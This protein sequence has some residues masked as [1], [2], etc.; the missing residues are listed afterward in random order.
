MARERPGP[1]GRSVPGGTGMMRTGEQY[2]NEFNDGRIVWVS[3]T[4]TPRGP[5]K[6]DNYGNLRFTV[7][8]RKVE[9]R[10]S[11]LANVTVI[12]PDV[13]Q[14]P[15]LQSKEIHRA[16]GIFSRLSAT[17]ILNSLAIHEQRRRRAG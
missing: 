9:K 6:F 7:Y 12:Y 13:S 17:Q 15:A 14:F 11:K 10:A 16:A 8:V 5:V 3:L 4:G 1:T 2:L